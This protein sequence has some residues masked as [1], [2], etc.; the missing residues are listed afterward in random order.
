MKVLDPG[1]DRIVGDA[2]RG[3]DDQ[4]G[5][6]RLHLGRHHPD[7]GNRECGEVVAAVGRMSR[8]ARPGRAAQAIHGDIGLAQARA[9]DAFGQDR[10]DRGVVLW[11]IEPERAHRPPEAVDVIVE[12]E[13]SAAPDA[14]DVIGDVRPAIAPIGDRNGGFFDRHMAAV[15]IGGP[16]RPALPRHGVPRLLRPVRIEHPFAVPWQQPAELI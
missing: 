13:E 10:G 16:R 7:P 12:A 3:G 4:M 2:G 5:A 1:I 14:D 9:A 6:A 11:R 8:L 15:D